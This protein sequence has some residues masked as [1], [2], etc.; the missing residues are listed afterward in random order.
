M[1]PLANLMVSQE[2]HLIEY[3]RRRLE[4]YRNVEE[5]LSRPSVIT[6]SVVRFSEPFDMNGYAASP[7]S[8]DLLSDVYAMFSDRTRRDESSRYLR[9]L[10]VQTLSI[11]ATFKF[12]KKASI[13]MKTEDGEER[14]TP[15]KGG[16]LSG[17]NQSNETVVWVSRC[18]P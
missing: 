2:F 4:Y 5:T 15:M 12:A 3:H 11:D 7:I 17:I 6:I 10:P 13:V 9:S 1:T 18:I 14:V 16:V 8:D